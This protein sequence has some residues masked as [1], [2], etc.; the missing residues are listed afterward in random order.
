[1]PGV[2]AGLGEEEIGLA[3][4]GEEMREEIEVEIDSVLGQSAGNE[5]DE[6]EAESLSPFTIHVSLF[7]IR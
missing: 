6:R 5:K 2:A 7:V 4:V 1:M 3:V